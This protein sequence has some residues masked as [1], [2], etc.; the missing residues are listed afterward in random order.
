MFK[1][2]LD[3]RAWVPWALDAW[4]RRVFQTNTSEDE[5]ER[6]RRIELLHLAYLFL[7]NM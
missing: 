3:P 5:D 1:E 4:A 6:I 2:A 7:P